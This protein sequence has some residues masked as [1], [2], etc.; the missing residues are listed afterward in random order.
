MAKPLLQVALDNFSI[1][2]ALESTRILAPELDIIE[3]GTILCLSSGS[4]AI[5]VMNT[6]YPDNIIVADLKIVDA[7]GELAGMACDK[8]ADWVTVMCNA[9]D[10]T[11][12]KAMEAAEKRGGEMQVE[13]FGNWT[14]EQA[15]TWKKLGLKQ[16]I[17]HQSRDALNSGG[18]WGSENMNVVKKLADMG[19]EV[20]V[21]GGL[22]KDV[23]QLFKGIPV[24]SFIVGRNLRNADDPAA[25]ARTYQ[26][27]IAK[28]WS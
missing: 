2:E 15:E 3:I 27:E 28:Y 22:T 14:Y 23:I 21:T 20:S 12:V 10:A 1:S 4:E 16:V 5:E 13:L 19:L 25:E 24:K 17:Y 7:G 9:A 11:K 26:D 8:G 6:L 18:S